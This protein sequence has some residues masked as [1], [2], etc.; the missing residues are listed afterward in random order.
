MQ[1]NLST[2]L[3]IPLTVLN[4]GIVNDLMIVFSSLIAVA[5]ILLGFRL[6]YSVI[7]NETNKDEVII[8]NSNYAEEENEEKEK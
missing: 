2:L 6:I 7:S 3:N 4:N 1:G 8:N 5:L